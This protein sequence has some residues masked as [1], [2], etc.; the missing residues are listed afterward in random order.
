[1]STKISDVPIPSVMKGLKRD[2]RG[3]PI[4][5]FV[6][7]IKGKPEFRFLD[8]KKKLLCLEENLCSICGQPLKRNEFYFISGPAGLANRTSSDTPMHLQCAEYSLQVCPYLHYRNFERREDE[9]SKEIQLQPSAIIPE[10]PNALYLI[11]SNCYTVAFV[12]MLQDPMVLMYESTGFKKYTYKD[13]LLVAEDGI[14]EWRQ[15]TV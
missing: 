3:Y 15:T 4:P 7:Y 13:N 9:L 5:F 8:P 14:L 2:K 1:M 11:R 6:G 10:K 12:R